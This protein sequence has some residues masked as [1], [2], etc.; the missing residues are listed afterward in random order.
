[1]RMRYKE[2]AARQWWSLLR[3]VRHDHRGSTLDLLSKSSR[4]PA[5][6]LEPVETLAGDV[7]ATSSGA[8]AS[9][10]SA[11]DTLEDMQASSKLEK[12]EMPVECESRPRLRLWKLQSCCL[13]LRT[14]SPSPRMT[15]RKRQFYA[16]LEGSWSWRKTS[17]LL[18]IGCRLQPSF[19]KSLSGHK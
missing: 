19:K 9:W 17:E 18:E 6:R 15:P 14:Q 7:G 8:I 13:C 1:M 11:A 4:S 5:D 3:L 10:V 12:D 16:Q 2:W